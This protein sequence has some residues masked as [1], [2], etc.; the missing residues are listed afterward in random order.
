MIRMLVVLLL[1]FVVASQPA[2][3]PTVAA[4][5]ARLQA[6]DPGGAARILEA[7]T[8]REPTNGRAWRMLGAAY[9]QNKELEKALA[10]YRRAVELDPADAQAFYGIGTVYALKQDAGAAFEGLGEAKAT[11]RLDMTQIDGDANL[12]ALK[13]DARL[14]ALLP[15]AYDFSRPFV[16]LVQVIREWAG[17]AANDQFGWI[18]RVIGDVDRDG[19]TDIVT[20]APTKAIGGAAGGRG[21]RL[22]ATT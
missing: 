14:P 8:A 5:A 12:A 1:S 2:A 17:E 11:H 15:D 20:S 21:S 3:E 6:Q 10:A 9:Q 22:F 16:E 13:A 18:A 4:A 7:V 19:V